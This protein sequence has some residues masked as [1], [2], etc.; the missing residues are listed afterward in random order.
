[1]IT[2]EVCNVYSD[3]SRYRSV[4]QGGHSVMLT[5]VKMLTLL[6]IMVAGDTDGCYKLFP[7]QV[8]YQFTLLHI[9]QHMTQALI[10]HCISLCSIVSW[11]N[12]S[13]PCS[14]G[15]IPEYLWGDTTKSASHCMFKV[16]SGLAA[17]RCNKLPYIVAGVTRHCG[18]LYSLLLSSAAKYVALP[19]KDIK[20]NSVMWW[21]TV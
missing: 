20:T 5:F 13:A 3:T 6:C 21:L 15:H 7:V 11:H 2:S 18:H 10:V 16:I 9:L 12:N 1:M 19:C 14:V 4:L 17:L 8:Q